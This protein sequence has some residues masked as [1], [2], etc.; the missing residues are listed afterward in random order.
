[1]SAKQI[2]YIQKSIFMIIKRKKQY[3][4]F[5]I[6]LF[7]LKYIDTVLKRNSG[8]IKDQHRSYSNR[9]YECIFYNFKF[10]NSAKLNPSSIYI[11]CIS[12]SALHYMQCSTSTSKISCYYSHSRIILKNK[13]LYISHMCERGMM[14]ILYFKCEKIG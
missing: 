5:S 7:F 14:C 4:L 9:T 3:R 10:L 2:I 8:P 1:M 6:S 12:P 13:Y 11:I